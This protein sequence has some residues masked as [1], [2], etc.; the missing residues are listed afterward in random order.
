MALHTYTP[1]E[2][3]NAPDH[4]TTPINATNLNNIETGIENAYTDISDLSNE[5]AAVDLK[6]QHGIYE[7]WENPSPSAAFAGQALSP[8][9][10]D[11]TIDSLF[12][13]ANGG[14]LYCVENVSGTTTLTQ[15]A[16]RVNQGQIRYIT[17]GITLVVSSNTITISFGDCTLY[18]MSSWTSPSGTTGNTNLVPLRIFGVIHNE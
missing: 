13:E 3:K 7:L 6:T 10:T 4:K 11:K 12:I 17:R 15:T 18:D 16:L 9:T 2:W 8:I 14:R 1:T 5:I